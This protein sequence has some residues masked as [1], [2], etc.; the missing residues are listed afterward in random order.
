MDNNSP[1]DGIV[2]NF[3]PSIIIPGTRIVFM[4]GFFLILVPTQTS[5][6]RIVLGLPSSYR[7]KKFDKVCFFFKPFNYNKH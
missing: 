5:L 2:I 7:F 3:K 6:H 4:N 1:N